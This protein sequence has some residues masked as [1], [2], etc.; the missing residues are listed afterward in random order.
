MS[1][2]FLNPGLEG[3]PVYLPGR[4][5]EDVARE[6]G[7]DPGTV[8]KLASNE[9]PLGPSPAALEAVRCMLGQMHLYPDGGAVR[10]R[11]ALGLRLG[12]EGGNLILGNGSNE[13]IELVGHATLRPADEVVVSQYCF[14]VYPIVAHLF[15]A[16][17]VQVPAREF[18]HDLEAMLGA[19]TSR[20]R[21]MF[22]AN[23]NNPTGTVVER[24][25]LVHLI[26]HV[27]DHV[28]L[29]M[30]E[31]YVEFLDDPVDFLPFIRDERKRNLILM[32][33]FSK[34]HGLAGLR[35]GY[36]IA[37]PE[38][39]R[40]LERARQPFNLNAVAQVAAVA[41]LGDEAHLVRTRLNNAHGLRQLASGLA[42]LGIRTLP[43]AA[44]FLLAHVGN[45][46]ETFAA[47]QRRG[48]ITRPVASYGLPEWLRIS[49]GTTEE[50]HRFL[51][52]I[53]EVRGGPSVLN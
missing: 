16:R 29:V 33:T 8:I 24:E 4:P 28:L 53:G 40:A 15:G 6:M 27:P 51:T 26:N 44:N 39:V 52:A 43:S 31:A 37:V 30:D 38:V 20:T 7:L 35:V 10:L 48:V 19:V 42:A 14:A 45:G 2:P 34:I 36:G 22:V 12:L 47:L 41:A 49:V 9:N 5:I 32:R 46:A 3:L 17:L 21:L 1:T 50:N 13:I 11:Q 25:E 18:G 23:P